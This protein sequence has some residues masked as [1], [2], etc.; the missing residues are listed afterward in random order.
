LLK[1]AQSTILFLKRFFEIESWERMRTLYDVQQ[2]LKK[3]GI[4]VYIG[5]RMADLELMELELRGLY[6]SKLVETRDFEMALLIIRQEKRKEKE[7][8]NRG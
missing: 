5:N 1:A 4:I 8:R 7:K 2:L 6:Q 3:F